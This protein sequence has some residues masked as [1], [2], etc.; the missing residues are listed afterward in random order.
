MF[1]F[2]PRD[3]K[4]YSIYSLTDTLTANYPATSYNSSTVG[5]GQP[6]F[7]SNFALALSSNDSGQDNR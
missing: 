7:L 3:K 6:K 1:L 2:T 4:Y 5:Q